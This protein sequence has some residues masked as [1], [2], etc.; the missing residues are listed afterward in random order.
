[1]DVKVHV[2]IN[3][4]GIIITFVITPGNVSDSNQKILLKIT[5][6]LLGKLFGARGYIIRQDLC[7]TLYIG[8]SI[9]LQNQKKHEK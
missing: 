4:L 6:D 5:G 1:M 9:S 2:V 7:E 8:A 3:H